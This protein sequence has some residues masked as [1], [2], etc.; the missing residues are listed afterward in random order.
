LDR[1][2]GWNDMDLFDL[3]GDFSPLNGM[4]KSLLHIEAVKKFQII[5]NKYQTNHNNRNSKLQTIGI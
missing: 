5:K 2:D 1:L 4:R 3:A